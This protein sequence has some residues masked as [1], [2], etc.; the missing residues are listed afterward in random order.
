[1]GRRVLGVPVRE[2]LDQDRLVVYMSSPQ[3]Q[4]LEQGRALLLG[5]SGAQGKGWVKT[6]WCLDILMQFVCYVREFI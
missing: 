4:G 5:T 1:M 3:E 2:V 6:D